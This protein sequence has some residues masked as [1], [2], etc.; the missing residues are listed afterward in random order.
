MSVADG[1]G[2]GDMTS[3]QASKA[4]VDRPRNDLAAALTACRSAIVALAVASA[5][6]NILYLS[7][8]L[9]MLEVYDRVLPSRSIPTLV[10]LSVL[11]VALYGFQ[12]FLDLLRGR[13][14]VRIGRSLG[15]KLSS[16]VYRTIAE[17]TLKTR[18]TGDGLQPL[19]DLDQIRSFLSSQGPLAF[20]D[21]PWIPFYIGICFI[22][23]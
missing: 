5:I 17:L 20:L 21:L 12:A 11:V 18:T 10:G 1:H 3:G 22:F 7:G 2:G 15:Q 6:I 14:L 13:V 23:H 8:S 4:S 9:Y 19:R 16:R